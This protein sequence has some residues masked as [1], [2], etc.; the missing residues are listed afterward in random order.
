ML[1]VA[2]GVAAVVLSRCDHLNLNMNLNMTP[3]SCNHL[4]TLS[5]PPGPKSVSVAA[6]VAPDIIVSILCAH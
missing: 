6:A 3:S 1:F 5:S 2:V 4:K